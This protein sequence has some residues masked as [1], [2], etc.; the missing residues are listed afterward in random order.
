MPVIPS[1]ATA[2]DL[3]TIKKMHTGE[4]PGSAISLGA[5]LASIL[6]ANEIVNIILH[7]RKIICA[8]DFIYVDLLDQKYMVKSV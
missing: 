7:K 6:A 2:V 1:Y 4:L 3:E 5:G 8:P